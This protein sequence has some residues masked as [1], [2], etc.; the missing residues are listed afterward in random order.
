[1]V[2]IAAVT[3]ILDIPI[4]RIYVNVLDFL[5]LV[6]STIVV[7]TRSITSI[8]SSKIVPQ[9]RVFVE[10]DGFELAV[11]VE[12]EDHD[13]DVV[14]KADDRDCVDELV[15]VVV[16]GHVYTVLDRGQEVDEEGDCEEDTDKDE[17]HHA[18]V[19]TLVLNHVDDEDEEQT[20]QCLHYELTG[21][22]E[23]QQHDHCLKCHQDLQ[24]SLVR[25]SFLRWRVHLW[26]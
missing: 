11:G 9:S 26:S 4:I 22:D 16:G 14:D 20:D 10:G 12:A 21:S 13:E 24:A 2:I 1:M 7:V 18:L 23:V 25:L 8:A 3:V 6:V 17:H 15:E 19:A 5:V